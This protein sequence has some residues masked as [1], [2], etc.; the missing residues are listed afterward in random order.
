LVSCSNPRILKL[1]PS[2]YCNVVLLCLADVL[3]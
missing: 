3:A 2:L 1:L